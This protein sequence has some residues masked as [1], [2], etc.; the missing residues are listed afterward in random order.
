MTVK[1]G[2]SLLTFIVLKPNRLFTLFTQYIL[3]SNDFVIRFAPLLKKLN[4][5]ISEGQKEEIK[6][7]ILA[8]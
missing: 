3:F 4:K 1:T 2:K 5:K 6:H 8:P 7:Q